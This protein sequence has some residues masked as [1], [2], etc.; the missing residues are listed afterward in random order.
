MK[1]NH[2]TRAITHTVAPRG[3]ALFTYLAVTGIPHE[4]SI[5]ADLL[6]SDISE[7]K[8]KENLRYV[9]YDLKKVLGDYLEITR[10]TI[11]FNQ[12]APYWLDTEAFSSF[13]GQINPLKFLDLFEHALQVYQSPFLEGFYIRRA[14]VFEEWVRTQQQHFQQDFVEG[15]YQCITYGVEQAD[16]KTGLK[17][18]RQLLRLEPWNED[19]HVQHMR[20]L[21]YDGQ[22]SAALAQYEVCRRMV[23][24][25]YSVEPLPETQTLY[26]QIRNNNFLAL[27]SWPCSTHISDT[28]PLL[29]RAIY[30]S[31]Y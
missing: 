17:A 9:L 23:L 3:L 21:A 11:A 25:E 22:R 19:A 30:Q 18:S 24:D 20:L 5:I 31:T 4:R 28:N 6:W 12:Y 14:P 13:M 2:I 7:K 8:A 16:Y 1:K 10:R 15:L 27:Q 29:S 26:Q